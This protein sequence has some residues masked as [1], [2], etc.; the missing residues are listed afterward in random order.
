MST[1]FPLMSLT[2]LYQCRCVYNMNERV[3]EELPAQCLVQSGNS[4]NIILTELIVDS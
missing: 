2:S 1:L 3:C 4:K